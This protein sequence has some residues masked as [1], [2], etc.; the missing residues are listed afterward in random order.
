MRLALKMSGSKAAC[1]AGPVIRRKPMITT[2]H[3]AHGKQDKVG[4]IKSEFLFT[5]FMSL[6]LYGFTVHCFVQVASLPLKVLRVLRPVVNADAPGAPI[7]NTAC[8][9]SSLDIY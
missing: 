6:L 7:Y 1:D 8:L 9:L 5:H 4:L 2:K 3:H